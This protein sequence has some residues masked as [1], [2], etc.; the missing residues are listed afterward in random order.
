MIIKSFVNFL[1]KNQA[2][3][4]EHSSFTFILLPFPYH[5]FKAQ[6]MYTTYNKIKFYNTLLLSC[7]FL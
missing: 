6:H 3:K 4:N 2:N 1:V 7:M 5:A